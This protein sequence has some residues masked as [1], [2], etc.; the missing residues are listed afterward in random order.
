M[1]SPVNSPLKSIPPGIDSDNLDPEGE[2]HL[3]ESLLYE[4]SSPRPPKDSNSDVSDAITESFSPSPIPFEDSDSLMEEI[5]LFL[6][7]DDS[8]PLGIETDDYDSEGDILFFEELLTDDS[9]SLPEHESFH[10]ESDYD[11]SSPRPPA[12]PPDD[13]EIEPDTGLLTTKVVGEI[14]E[15]YVLMPRLLPTQPTLCP[16]IQTLLPFSSENVDKVLLLSHRGF[17]ALQLSSKSPML[18]HGDN[19]PNLGVRHLHFYPP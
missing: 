18:I 16:V 13:D 1:S 14:S 19:T 7:L 4:N 9:L 17:K 6:T 11:P 3:V 2:I 12:K 5:D 10:F 15:H 8:M